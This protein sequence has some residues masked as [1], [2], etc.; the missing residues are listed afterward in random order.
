MN[1]LNRGTEGEK[2]NSAWENHNDALHT[3]FPIEETLK[4]QGGK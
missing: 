4:K 3:L 1:N 2:N